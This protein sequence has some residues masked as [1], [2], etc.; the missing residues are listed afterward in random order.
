[1]PVLVLGLLAYGIYWAYMFIVTYWY[2]VLAGAVCIWGGPIVVRA[3]SQK[4]S[5]YKAALKQQRDS[6][7]FLN[8]HFARFSD[9]DIVLYSF[10]LFYV[11]VIIASLLIAYNAVIEVSDFVK[12]ERWIYKIPRDYR[13]LQYIAWPLFFCLVTITMFRFLL[14]F[15]N[16]IQN[17]ALLFPSYNKLLEHARLAKTAEVALEYAPSLREASKC[18]VRSFYDLFVFLHRITTKQSDTSYYKSARL[19]DTLTYLESHFPH[20]NK[21]E[22]LRRRYWN[23]AR[24]IYKVLD[25]RE[26]PLIENSLF[27]LPYPEDEKI[28]EQEAQEHLKREREKFKNEPLDVWA[29]SP[30]E[31]TLND[32]LEIVGMKNIPPLK[33]LH[34]LHVA[35][36]ED[37]KDDPKKARLT[38]KAFEVLGCEAVKKEM[39]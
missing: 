16:K 22:N 12:S 35:V 3:L 24:H 19:R 23:Y 20:E 37:H 36:L 6:E 30:H 29:K 28:K 38:A 31:I 26:D 7:H 15:F 2:F 4:L 11:L 17:N 5:S 25:F 13:D 18:H 21:D 8:D 27:A 33:V 39:S 9:K 34:K 14:F 1:M 10:H 32:A